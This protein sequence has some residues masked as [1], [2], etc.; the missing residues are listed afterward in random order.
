MPSRTVPRDTITKL[1]ALY[2]KAN[3]ELARLA[4]E[5]RAVFETALK[6]RVAQEMRIAR[7]RIAAL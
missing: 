3:A 5:R 7:Q 2:E 1:G 6:R 4:A